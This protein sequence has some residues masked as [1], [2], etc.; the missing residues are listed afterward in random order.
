[1]GAQSGIEQALKTFVETLIE[2]PKW[3][4]AISYKGRFIGRF[5]EYEDESERAAREAT[6]NIFGNQIQD[7][8][9]RFMPLDDNKAAEITHE[10]ASAIMKLMDG[11]KSERSTYT[12]ATG[13]GSYVIWFTFRY[14]IGINYSNF[15]IQAIDRT[16]ESI[17]N[18]IQ[19]LHDTI[20]SIDGYHSEE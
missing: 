10:Y 2:K 12:I 7:T 17:Y 6:T 9:T 16:L 20:W 15:G 13:D 8:E 19:D 1:M 3:V 18:N 5:G 11:L 4:L 14:I